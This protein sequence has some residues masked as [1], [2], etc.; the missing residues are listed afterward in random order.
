MA[1]VYY[2]TVNPVFIGI[3]CHAGLCP[4]TVR[5]Q[6][7]H[8]LAIPK[9]RLKLRILWSKV[10]EAY[11]IFFKTKTGEPFTILDRCVWL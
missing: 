3:E 6:V 5:P 11:K 4:S 2:S 7:Y 1:Q 9:N 10:H 8:R